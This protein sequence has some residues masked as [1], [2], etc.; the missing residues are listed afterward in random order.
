MF[1]VAA[2]LMGWMDERIQL[3]KL[4]LEDATHLMLAS[5]L[6]DFANDP[7][8]VSDITLVVVG[9]I[10][11]EDITEIESLVHLIGI[12]SGGVIHLARLAHVI[13]QAAMVFGSEGTSTSLVE[14]KTSGNLKSVLGISRRVIDADGALFHHGFVGSSQH[15]HG[16]Q[17]PLD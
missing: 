13:I 1:V 12:H 5:H 17:A 9:Q 3:T 6:S 16:V 7:Q 2:L 14:R 15:Q 10:E 8:G 11:Y 4:E